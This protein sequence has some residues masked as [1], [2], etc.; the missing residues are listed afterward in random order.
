MAEE[1]PLSRGRVAIVDDA[2]FGWLNQWKWFVSGSDAS[3]WYAARKTVVNGK[4]VNL[5][6]HRVILDAPAGTEVDHVS[7]DTLDN[8][9]AN[10]R[11]CTHAQNCQNRRRIAGSHSSVFHGVSWHK[12]NRKWVA[13]IQ[14]NGRRKNLGYYLSEAEA[15]LAYNEVAQKHYGEFAVLNRM[16]A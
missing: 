11:L 14:I 8:R 16:E 4:R 12:T 7:R 13:Q 3:N 1:I 5:R 6:M 10:L 9:R 2:D 15:A